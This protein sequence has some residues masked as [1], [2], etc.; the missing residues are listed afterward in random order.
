MS[1]A[2]ALPLTIE[3]PN[4]AG[5]MIVGPITLAKL[6]A[7]TCR[8]CRCSRSQPHTRRNRKRGSCPQARSRLSSRP[9]LFEHRLRPIGRGPASVPRAPGPTPTVPVATAATG[10]TDTPLTGTPPTGL[11]SI[12]RAA[13]A[14]TAVADPSSGYVDRG[15]PALRS[16]PAAPAANSPRKPTTDAPRR[17]SI[18]LHEQRGRAMTVTTTSLARGRAGVRDPHVGDPRRDLGWH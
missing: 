7:R 16:A 12:S 15:T 10:L 17:S 1:T 3:A 13:L 11:A 8:L 6:G 18:D 2:M 4:T 14:H 9:S 5:L